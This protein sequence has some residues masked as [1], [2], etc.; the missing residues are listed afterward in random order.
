MKKQNA[1][2]YRLNEQEFWPGSVG[3]IPTPF[4]QPLDAIDLLLEKLKRFNYVMLVNDNT[5]K[6]FGNEFSFLFQER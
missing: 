1:F 5:K 4:K 2:H 6:M 3:V